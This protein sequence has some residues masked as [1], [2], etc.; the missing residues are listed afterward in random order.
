MMLWISGQRDPHKC[1]PRFITVIPS[2]QRPHSDPRDQN[3]DELTKYSSEQGQRKRMTTLMSKPRMCHIPR[4]SIFNS[5][6]DRV[7]TRK[8]GNNVGEGT[9][10][11]SSLYCFQPSATIYT[12]DNDIKIRGRWAIGE[13]SFPSSPASL[14][15]KLNKVLV[16]YT[17]LETW[18]RNSLAPS[19]VR[20]PL[21]W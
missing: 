19:D 1:G 16:E 14:I 8:D 12:Q 6:L 18:N 7:W 3:S 17:S 13:N 2:T 21:S 10:W 5:N 4:G 9:L 15:S 11:H 20:F